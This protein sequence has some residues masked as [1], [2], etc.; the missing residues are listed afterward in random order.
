[1]RHAALLFA[2]G[3]LVGA[4]AMYLTGSDDAVPSLANV[5]VTGEQLAATT[6]HA[7]ASARTIDVLELVAGSIDTIER[8][9]L[10][11]FAADADRATLESLVAQIA[12]LPKIPSRA[13]AL[14]IMLTR[15]AEV[16]GLAAAALARK[17]ELEPAAV[18]ALFVAWARRD[19]GAA[20]RALGDLPAP[21][22]RTIGV[23]LLAVLGNDDLGIVRVLGA[24]PQLDA[25]RFRVEAAIAKAATEP[26]AAVEDAVLLP[27]SKSQAALAGIATAWAKTDPL[28]ALAR[29]DHIDD[30]D[31]RTAF[32]TNVLRTWATVDADALLAYLVDLP[33]DEQA[34][35]MRVGAVQSSV[36][37][38]EP[39][40]A[41]E[42][43]ESL[44]G[45]LGALL[46]RAALTGLA[47]DEPLTA[48]RRVEALPPGS[49][50]EQLMSM[51]AQSYG[52]A[53]PD[54]AIAW[55]HA[56]APELLTTVLVG[57]ARGD[58][59]RAM[60]MLATAGGT[61]EQQRLVQSLVVSRALTSEQMAALADR[62][63]AAQSRAP[64]L[65]M[66]TSAWAQ[67]SPEDALNWLLA[68]P[69]RTTAR[70]VGQAGMNLAAANPAAA[71]AYLE[72]VPGEL[73]ANWL[74]AVA[75]GYAQKDAR[76]AA[77]W[78][79]QHRGE[80]GY[81]AAVAAV[82]ARTAAHDPA[83]AARLFEAVDIS[84]APDAPGNARMIAGMWARQDALAAAAW[85]HR[86]ADADTAA[87]AVSAVASQW[88]AR[89]AA[90][91]RSWAMGLPRDAARDAALVQILGATA[92]TAAT[93][94]ALI[95][96]FSSLDAQQRGLNEAV[97]IIAARDTEVARQLADRYITDPGTRQAAERFIEQG[98]SSGTFFRP[99]PRVAPA[100]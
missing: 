39:L 32:K 49:E 5:T 88:A 74:S 58:P 14:E 16:D 6:D 78:V 68:N 83:A 43:A 3:L 65:Q 11:R 59:E 34:E 21:T 79:A 47:R 87:G 27:A 89:D 33:P 37:M 60:E 77:T 38:L 76:A 80:A 54:A 51:I 55:A 52:R 20:L 94:T 18:E 53:D 46:R 25:D 41:L 7:A 75:E 56:Q 86:L 70:A 8:A 98:A 93:D 50:R 64:A 45:E 73:R 82:A 28:G 10:Y 71:I 95:D 9:A 81:D 30:P 31:L 62:L 40:R 19:A 26:E 67:R 42:V 72:R 24:A 36:T 66:L 17:L 69:N 1:M 23:A 57:V 48:L 61:Q 99:P 97:R 13:A 2:A 84:Q 100:R 35:A 63:L 4:L 90:A 92:G 44:S 12:A 96:A 29:V 22:A 85:A 15:Y 91:A